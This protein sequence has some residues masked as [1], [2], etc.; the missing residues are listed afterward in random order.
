MRSVRRIDC[1]AVG[2]MIVL[3]IFRQI[4][5]FDIYDEQE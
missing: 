2:Q 4:R 5:S 1:L 3:R